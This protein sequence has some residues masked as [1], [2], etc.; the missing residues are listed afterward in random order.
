MR[1]RAGAV[2]APAFFV[3]SRSRPLGVFSS[4]NDS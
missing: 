1:D 2:D 4:H 3:A